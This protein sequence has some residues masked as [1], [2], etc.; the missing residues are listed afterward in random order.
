MHHFQGDLSAQVLNGLALNGIDAQALAGIVHEL[1]NP[2]TTILGLS[3]LALRE[4][5]DP[6]DR[7]RRIQAEAER[8]VQIVHNVLN[9]YRTSGPRRS[10]VNLN[11]TITQAANLANPRLSGGLIVLTLNLHE[12][13][14]VVS[15]NPGEL[16]QVFL[17]LITN[18]AQAITS[19]RG[20]GNIAIST[21]LSMNR[22]RVSV[23]DDGPGIKG[24]DIQKI[25]EPFFTTKEDGNGLGLSLS[26][27]I[28]HQ[29]GGD[30]WVTS[31]AL[32]GATFTIDL[33]TVIDEQGDELD[34]KQAPANAFLKL[35]TGK[36]VLVVDD[37][38]Q[39]AQLVSSVLQEKGYQSESL[40]EGDRAMSLLE[41]NPYDLLVC[42]Y[43]MPGTSGR[44]LLEWIRSA[45]KTTR[46]IVLSGD[47]LDRTTQDAVE[48][49]GGYFLPKP[50]S[51]G[52]LSAAV[53]QVMQA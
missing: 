15:A 47:L 33:P 1:N 7:I 36:S 32:Q 26:R 46:V 19:F 51:I 40:T 17:N 35:D 48:Y 21:F 14:P 41:R 25:F 53:D 24:F 11:E 10:V 27:K 42:D 3:E 29:I 22:V 6:D 43:H 9:L 39:I 44:E 45:G 13:S 23:M 37:E 20:S 5:S 8:S 34:A 31:H 38:E 18:A 50:F 28:V 49:L 2:L 12:P 52:D 16:T 4:A 30:I